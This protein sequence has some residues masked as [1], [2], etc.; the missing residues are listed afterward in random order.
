MKLTILGSGTGVPNGERNSAGYFVET[1]DARVMMDCGAGTV[2]ALAR[3]ALPWERMTH[4]FVSHFHVDHIGELASLFF[5]FRHG[6]RTARTEPLTVL[7]PRGLDQVTTGLKQA[8]GS[9]LFDTRFPVQLRILA[10]GERVAL[11]PDTILSVA[12]TPHTDESLA[13][14]IDSGGG[15]VCYTGDTGY[16]EELADFFSETD[17]LISECSFRT[18]RKGVAHLSIEDAARIAAQA[19]AARLVAT[20]FYFDVN[21]DALKR[22]L[23]QG[24]GGE[25]LIGRD[26]MSI[27]F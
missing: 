8:F 4:L 15:S 10:P 25:V 3:Y 6:L 9:T 2:H 11:G 5:A 17:V 21:E 19:N 14:R 13:V 1:A 24:Y 22:E 18:R 7:G 27:V 12:K 26:G 16:T 20:H 23:Q